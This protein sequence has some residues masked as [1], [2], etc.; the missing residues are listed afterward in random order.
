[1]LWERGELETPPDGKVE[2][3]LIDV[4][5]LTE[6]KEIYEMLDAQASVKVP[7]DHIYGAC[8]ETGFQLNS[9]LLRKCAFATQLKIATTGKK[10]YGDI[11]QM[12]KSWKHELI[13]LDSM[14]LQSQNTILIAVMLIAIRRDGLEKAKEFFHKLDKNQGL[15][16]Q[17]GYDGIEL[18]GR[19][20]Q[21]RRSEKR[22]AGYENL[23]EICG[24]AWTA[25][26]MWLA[27]SHRKTASLPI[28]DFTKVVLSVNKERRDADASN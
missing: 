10:F 23:M 14:Q 11:L 6:A 3:V 5:G 7:A 19:V 15:K 2:V 18:L 16:S 9:C 27:K 4:D 26:E 1:M 21:V 20:L 8:R 13:A 12:V 22:T 28:A 25:Y 24:Q 17:K